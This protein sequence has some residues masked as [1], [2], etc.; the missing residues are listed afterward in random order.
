MYRRKGYYSQDR[1]AKI[2]FDI[3]IEIFLP[4]ERDFSILF[5]VECKN[6]S[7]PVPVDDAEEFF[8]KVQQVGAANAKAVLASTAAFQSGTIQ[9]AKSKKM[10]LLRYFDSEHFKWELHRSPSASARG[11]SPEAERDVIGGL[12]RPD[13]RSEVFDLFLQTPTRGTNS[14]WDL[15]NDVI[16]TTTLSI[17]EVRQI[18][19]P[20]NR[21]SNLVPFKEKG[22]IEALAEETLE[23]ISYDSGPVS[24]D[25]ICKR[26]ASR[27]GLVVERQH[28]R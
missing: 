12:S 10:G 8:T 7:H 20:P 14:L 26:E 3:S 16:A 18:A 5:L 2:I 23:A 24:L 13:F 1:K 9:F 25:A 27:C 19:N 15:F 28:R 4:G 22:D 6:Y 11:V 17:A 21:Q